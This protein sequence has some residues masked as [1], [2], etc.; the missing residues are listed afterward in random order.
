MPE[1]LLKLINEG[2]V[3]ISV[4]V[5]TYFF[6]GYIKAESKA[7]AEERAANLAAMERLHA[8]HLGNNLRIATSMEKS[9]ASLG[10]AFTELMRYCSSAKK[11]GV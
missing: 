6:I 8:S 4:I 7:S 2:G 5:I 3:G 11:G 1:G 10:A 9:A